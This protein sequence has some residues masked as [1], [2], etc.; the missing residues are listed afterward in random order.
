[1]AVPS[2]R[3]K[4]KPEIVANGVVSDKRKMLNCCSHLFQL[5]TKCLRFGVTLNEEFHSFCLYF[6]LSLAQAYIGKN[7]KLISI[8]NTNIPIF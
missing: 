2:S 4:T 5:M 3:S 1:M 8:S 6:P 7:S